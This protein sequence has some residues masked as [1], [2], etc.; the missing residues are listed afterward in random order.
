MNIRKMIVLAMQLPEGIEQIDKA[1]RSVRMI[2]SAS[3]RPGKLKWGI[4]P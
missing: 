4:A 3:Y 1:G 2:R